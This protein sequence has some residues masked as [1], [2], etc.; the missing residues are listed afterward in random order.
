MQKLMDSTVHH[1][2]ISTF[3]RSRNQMK[4]CREHSE[5]TLA[6]FLK[7]FKNATSDVETDNCSPSAS[8]ALLWSVRF[9]EHC[10]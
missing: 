4:N 7:L 2:E 8:L 6:P 5:N 1:H 10:R 9:I 3:L